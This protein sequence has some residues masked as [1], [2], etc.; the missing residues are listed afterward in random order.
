[1]LVRVDKSYFLI[2]IPKCGFSSLEE[3]RQA[4][5]VP[6]FGSSFFLRYDFSWLVVI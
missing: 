4:M 6:T 2:V 5:L 1:M 3:T